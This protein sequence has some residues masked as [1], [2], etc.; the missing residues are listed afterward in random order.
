MRPPGSFIFAKSASRFWGVNTFESG[1]GKCA[2]K[3]GDGER[4]ASN[5]SGLRARE[6][7]VKPKGHTL[8]VFGNWPVRRAVDEGTENSTAT[9]LI[10]TQFYW[11]ARGVLD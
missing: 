10:N 11:G 4:F 2:R 5:A 3:R 9:S 7:T 8:C 6:R 1:E